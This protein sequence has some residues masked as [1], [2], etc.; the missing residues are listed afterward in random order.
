M[1]SQTDN[2]LLAQTNSPGLFTMGHGSNPSQFGGLLSLGS[3]AQTLLKAEIGDDVAAE[4]KKSLD[5]S[6]SKS[7]NVIKI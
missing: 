6:L 2:S 5:Q 4:K 1:R 3:N 7:A